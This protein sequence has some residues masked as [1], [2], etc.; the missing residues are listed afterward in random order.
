MKTCAGPDLAPGHESE[1]VINAINECII[2]YSNIINV[3]KILCA[4]EKNRA[5]F[6]LM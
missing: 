2:Y 5:D 1:P 3:M 6:K 4:R